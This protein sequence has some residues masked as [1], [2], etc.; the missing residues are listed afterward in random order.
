MVQHADIDHTGLTGVGGTT[1]ADIPFTPAGTIAATNVQ[2]AIEEAVTEAAS[3]TPAF[4]GC[5]AYSTGAQNISVGGEVRFLLDSEVHDTDGYHF[6]S[7]ANLT[8]TVAKAAGSAVI[9][10]TGT[11]FTTELSVGQAVS[12][13]GTAVETFI[14]SVIT[15]NTHFTAYQTSVNTAT[16]Q[17]AARV[18]SVMAIR[19]AGYYHMEATMQ[20]DA[21]KSCY[22]IL[23]RNN[24]TNWQGNG[25]GTTGEITDTSNAKWL[26]AGAITEHLNVGDFVSAAGAGV[27]TLN[28]V[29]NGTLSPSLRIALIG[30]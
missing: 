9:T 29:A 19:V 24:G 17:T 4:H 12:I 27:A 1:A 6:T 28:T 16:G 22:L 11:S 10:G 13:P 30:T 14:V 7:A 8:G 26:S 21:A 15:D 5:W 23:R 18:N 25:Q 2:D 3:G 20:V